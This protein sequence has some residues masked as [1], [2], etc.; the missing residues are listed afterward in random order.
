MCILHMILGTKLVIR[1]AKLLVCP[2]DPRTLAPVAS[3]LHPDL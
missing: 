2:G 1:V 3:T